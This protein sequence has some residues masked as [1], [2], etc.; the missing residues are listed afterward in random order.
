MIENLA[1]TRDILKA[2]ADEK[3]LALFGTIAQGEF[4]DS[5]MLISNLGPSLKEYYMRLSRLMKARLTSRM[6]RKYSLT[7]L[8][9]TV[10]HA[11]LSI[12]PAVNI[13]PKLIAVDLL[14]KSS[15]IPEKEGN[16][17]INFLLDSDPFKNIFFQESYDQG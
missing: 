8:G 7:L 11:Q 4:G 2:L 9:K 5:E 12:Y 16:K 14:E 15:D 1:T 6:S 3:A 10:Y 13:Y 17:V